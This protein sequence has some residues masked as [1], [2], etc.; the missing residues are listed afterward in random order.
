MD[1]DHQDSA[2]DAVALRQ[3]I[4]ATVRALRTD[5]G[6]SLA[7][8]AVAAGIGKSTLHA[9]E[10]GEANPGIE[11]L[12]ALA[13]ALD[14]PF[15]Q[16]LEAPVPDMRVV[17]AGQGPRVGSASMEARLLLAARHRAHIEL[18]AIDLQPHQRHDARPHARGTMEHVLV[19]SG[20]AEVGP[21]DAQ[22]LLEPGDLASFPADVP[23]RYEALTPDTSALLL[24][25]YA[26]R[27]TS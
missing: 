14:V 16:L 27:T 25:D 18:Y 12:W 19:T 15:G 26:Q 2:D 5:A 24:I 20:R 13:R 6:R 3:R 7:D 9:I 23:H 4:A 1:W 22:A 10:A 17:R 8:V 11:T 21:I